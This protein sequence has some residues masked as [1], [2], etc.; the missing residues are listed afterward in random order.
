MRK[1]DGRLVPR[2]RHNFSKI[3]EKICS[4]HETSFVALY[5]SRNSG[6]VVVQDAKDQNFHTKYSGNL[7]SNFKNIGE[8]IYWI[9]GKVC[10]YPR[11]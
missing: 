11:K 7:L 9:H 10:L 4:L 5:E 3:Y 6:C 2:F 1:G 8:K